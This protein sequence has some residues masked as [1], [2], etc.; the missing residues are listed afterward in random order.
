MSKKFIKIAMQCLAEYK[1]PYGLSKLSIDNLSIVDSTLHIDIIFG[2]PVEL[3]RETIIADIQQLLTTALPEL[4]SNITISSHIR[5]HAVQFIGQSIPGVKNIIAIAAA[6]GGVGKSTTTVNLAFALSQAGAQVAILDADIYGPSIPKM[7]GTTGSPVKS[8]EGEK[9]YPVLASGIQTMSIAYMMPETAPIIW[10]GPMI[11]SGLLQLLN[12]TLWDNVDYLLLDLPPGTG[13][14]QLT[15]G[16]KIPV[17]AAVIVT[18]PQAVAL[19][20]ARR[21]V[22]MF[23]ELNIPMLGIIENMAYYICSQCHVKHPIFGENGG[24]HLAATYGVNLLGQLPLDRSIQAD[25]DAGKPTTLINPAGNIASIYQ[26]A[27]L[28]MSA[29]L[30]MQKINQAAR[31]PRIVVQ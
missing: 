5:A 12:N 16:Q 13:D 23:Q 26:D 27:A 1:P 24:K 20:D 6:K 14:I 15:L 21:G 18:T 7:L 3:I 30:S 9:F 17:S 22:E 10:R 2:F 8:D 28:R 25:A 29:Q 19:Q 4:S 11:S 31:F